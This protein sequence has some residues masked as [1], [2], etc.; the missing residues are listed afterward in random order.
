MTKIFGEL[1]ATM[2]GS[3]TASIRSRP[4]TVWSQTKAILILLFL[5][6]L[7][8]GTIIAAIVFSSLIG[9]IRHNDE[10]L[11]TD[12]ECKRFLSETKG[13]EALEWYRSARRHSFKGWNHDES[14]AFVK[15][16]YR[17][18]AKNITLLRLAEKRDDAGWIDAMIIEQPDD[19]EA[20]ERIFARIWAF[21]RQ[22]KPRQFPEQMLRRKYLLLRGP[23]T[24]D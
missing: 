24:T 16:L 10:I 8:L 21:L 20:K 6:S 17:L 5:F 18:G 7:P 19:T 14:L 13:R 3:A 2:N 11:S 4:S 22:E 9:H 15:D 23:A 12:A 1:E